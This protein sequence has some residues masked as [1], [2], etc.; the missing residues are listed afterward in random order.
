MRFHVNLSKEKYCFSFKRDF[1]YFSTHCI[2]QRFNQSEKRWVV[3]CR[4][5]AFCNKK[6][7]F[8]NWYGRKLALSK[9]VKENFSKEDGSL[10]WQM[11]F[12]AIAE[13]LFEDIKKE[14]SLQH[15]HL[16]NAVKRIKTLQHYVKLWE[17]RMNPCK[18]LR[19]RF[20]KLK[21][22]AKFPKKKNQRI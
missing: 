15:M 16:P 3:E 5:E 19:R 21:K 18:A 20:P 7:S 22:R 4:S 14:F 12:I 1:C 11:Y 9:L 13:P 6:H 2:C 8:D 10:I 17:Y